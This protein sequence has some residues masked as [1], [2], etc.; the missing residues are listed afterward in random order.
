M[1][2]HMSAHISAQAICPRG[3]RTAVPLAVPLFFAAA[4][5]G[6]AAA[7]EEDE[8]AMRTGRY[9][10]TRIAPSRAQLDPLAAQIQI[11]LDAEV[12]TVQQAVQS[13]LWGTGYRLHRQSPHL[14]LLLRRPVAASQRVLGPISIR[15]A[16]RLLAGPQWD[17]VEDPL[18][19]L[20]SFEVLPSWRN[21]L[22]SAGSRV[23]AK[24]V[25]PVAAG[26]SLSQHLSRPLPRP[27]SR[28]LPR[29]YR[30]R[31][32]SLR[33][34]I[35]ALTELWGWKLVGWELT[36]GD[37][38][39]L[40]W[41]VHTQWMLS[42]HSLQEGLERLLIPHNLRAVLHQSDGTVSVHLARQP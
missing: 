35:A 27:L 15:S 25:G 23:Q 5:A 21:L 41:R 36:L 10:I 26:E 14:N 17:L 31:P 30:V 20:I 6:A 33:D 3:W 37:G 11:Q 1:P 12:A 18:H 13:L 9:E 42:M 2:A 4:G 40:D 34:N 29:M 38:A 19:R 24:A 28:P 8:G 7:T 32:G 39:E 16:L 22:A